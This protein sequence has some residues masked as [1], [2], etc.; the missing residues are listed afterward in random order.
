MRWEFHIEDKPWEG[1][2]RLY[3][4]ATA[5]G[6]RRRFMVWPDME[7][8][9]D[10]APVSVPALSQTREEMQDGVGDV[11]NFLQAAMEVAWRNGLRPRGFSDTTNELA[12]T[13]R[14][15]EDMRALAIPKE[16]KP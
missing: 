4:V 10:G 5:N 1:S 2:K 16:I 3:I 13:R 8:V 14:H 15:L 11:D 9:E 7:E 12:A 6:Q